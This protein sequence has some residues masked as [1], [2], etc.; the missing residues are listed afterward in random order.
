MI[1]LSRGPR[2]ACSTKPVIMT[3]VSPVAAA[4][5]TDPSMVRAI[6]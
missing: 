5:G 2:A 1:V 6:R 3:M 4:S